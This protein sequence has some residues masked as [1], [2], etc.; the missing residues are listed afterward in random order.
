[1][2]MTPAAAPLPADLVAQYQRDGVIC[3]PRALAPGTVDLAREAFEW[4]LAHPG[5][6]AARLP[7]KGTGVF[8]Q[9]L[10]NPAALAAYRSLVLDSEIGDIVAALWQKP[11]VWFMYEQVFTKSGGTTRRTPW[12][13]DA[14]YLPVRGN[15]LAV[16]W[17]SFEPVP[18]E[19][20]LEFV[21]GS[22]HGALFDGSRFDPEDDT[23]PIYGDGSLPRLPD[24]EAD[25]D[26]FPIVSW[27]TDPGDV[28]VFH[29]A[30]LHGGGATTPQTSRRTLS[31]R[32]FGEDAVVATRPGRARAER[33][34]QT[35]DPAVH[36]L[37]RMRSLPDGAPFRDPAFPAIRPRT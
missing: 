11:H 30:M 29:P 20:A 13:Q 34:E 23:A 7:S 33:S 32:F 1:M 31:L 3:I 16:M 9:D 2:A 14:P 6:G 26:A 4:S 22:H 36:P 24:I 10:A 5:P 37:T 8:Y 15:D 35:K 19:Q 17:L 27:A 25:R 12:H 28:L 18:K 21:A